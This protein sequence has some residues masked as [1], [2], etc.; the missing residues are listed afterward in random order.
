MPIVVSAWHGT[1]NGGRATTPLPVIRE[2]RMA[3]AD[4]RV[5]P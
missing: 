5:I 3:S 1:E 2:L 4:T